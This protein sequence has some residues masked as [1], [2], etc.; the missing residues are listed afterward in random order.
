[1]EPR[2]W[3][4]DANV[5]VERER[6]AGTDGDA[7]HP[8]KDG[9][10]ALDLHHDGEMW[11]ATVSSWR[12]PVLVARGRRAGRG[13]VAEVQ[14]GAERVAVAREQDG[15]HV[16]VG[17]RVMEGTV[18]RLDEGTIEGVLPFGPIHP[19]HAQPPVGPG[20]EHRA[21]WSTPTASIWPALAPI[22][23][24]LPSSESPCSAVSV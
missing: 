24:L 21:H 13:L 23:L 11:Q 4:R 14:T 10:F 12:W 2:G 22:A 19:Q 6:D 8:R 18:Q 3:G 1:M 20:L 16:V 5:G 15:P 17:C 7:V 9:L